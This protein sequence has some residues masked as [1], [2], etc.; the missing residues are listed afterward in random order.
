MS[1]RPD[2]P[3]CVLAPLRPSLSLPARPARAANRPGGGTVSQQSLWIKPSDARRT[4]PVALCQHVECLDRAGKRHGKIDISARN[5]EL[6]TVGDQCNPD[7]HKKGERQHLRGGVLGD[8]RPT[9]AAAAYITI[10][11]M[12]TAAIIT[13]R[14][15]AI[16]IAVMIESREN[17]RSM[18]TS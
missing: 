10:M 3:S 17:T 12:T 18:A 16:P 15:S 5:M 7:Q 9:G 4:P 8:E 1:A 2:R 11:A 6:E 13:S 14:C